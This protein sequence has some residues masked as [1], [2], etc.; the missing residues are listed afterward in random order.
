[1]ITE[2]S[3]IDF[4]NKYNYDI[5]KTHNGRWIDQ[6]CT[7]DVVS[8]VADC[9][10]SYIDNVGKSKYSSKEIQY[11]DYSNDNVKLLFKKADTKSSLSAREYDKF[12]QQPMKMF[13]NAKILSEKKINGKNIFE[14]KERCILE[15]IALSEKNALKFIKNYIEKVL[16]DSEISNEFLSFFENQSENNF[17]KLKKCFIDF[18]HK[19]TN[20]KKEYEPKRIFT[21]VINPLA[22]FR[23][24]KGTEDGHL[25]KHIITYDMLMYNRDNFRD[26]YLGKPKDVTRKEYL[27]NHPIKINEDYYT[28]QSEK[29]KKFLRSFNDECRNGLSEYIDQTHKDDKATHIHHIF[30]KSQYPEICY[31][32]ENLIALTPTQHLNYAHPN[33]KTQEICLS[34]QHLLLLTKAERIKENIEYEK[35]L[36]DKYEIIYEF[37]KFLHVLSVG[38]DNDEIETIADKDFISVMNAINVYYAKK[39]NKSKSNKNI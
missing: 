6:K 19:N 24:S 32:L 39:N 5:R 36:S 31:Y 10:L 23:N 21:K 34:Y 12:F 16:S 17:N 15:Y 33:G 20:I 9:I 28:Y 22:Y 7:P 13:A 3:I 35:I 38:F 25:T 18:T 29:A 11:Y 14:L 26:I 37:S 8:F 1:M 27:S 2:L 30:P 4:V